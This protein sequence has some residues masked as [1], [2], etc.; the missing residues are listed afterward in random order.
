MNITETPAW[1]AL[2]EH[3]G[4]MK[5]RHLRELFASDPGRFSRFSLDVEG[6]LFDYSKQRIAPKTLDLLVALADAARLGTQIDALFSGAPVNRSEHRAALHM[7]LRHLDDS[8]FPSS[9][10]GFED[11][12]PQVRA[13]RERMG[14]LVRAIRDGAL[15]GASGEPIRAVVNLGVGGSGLG[16]KMATQALEHLAHPGLRVF[17]VSNFDD[18][19]LWPVLDKL[20]PRSTLF[21]VTSKTFTT[22]ETLTNA[23]SARDWLLSALGAEAAMEQFVAVTG[24]AEAAQAFGIR[25]DRV[26][27]FW[28]WVGG[29]FSLWSAVGLPIA[30][31]IGMEH[32][33]NFLAGGAA[34]DRHFRAAPFS[35]N[36]PVLMALIGIWNTNFLGAS[37][38]LLNPYCQ[39]L[40]WL[41]GY[42]QQLEMESNGKTLGDDAD[43]VGADTAPV[44]WGGIG[45]DTQH[46]Y[47]QLLH[48][49]GRLIPCD[50]IACAE[51]EAALPGHHEQLLANCLAQAEALAFGS[52][53]LGEEEDPRKRCP[54]NQPSSVF[55]LPRLGPFQLGLLIA[56]YEHK[57]FTQGAIWG[58]N[59]F[60]Q[61]GVE[62]GKKLARRLLPAIAGTEMPTG[63]D[64]STAG[65]IAWLRARIHER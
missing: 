33:E 12:M 63:S 65:L 14:E 48:Q 30:I 52:A 55:L 25:P 59:P 40:C 42:L 57:V 5:P 7:A 10:S 19:D 60:D 15:R 4:E 1:K 8:P 29:R 20:D 11:V 27:P 17:H 28:E 46:A 56:A 49:G 23:R 44:L 61:W 64:T 35:A 26:Y 58:I 43:P 41:P 18:A 34:M 31:S 62:L 21:I 9:D 36:L 6:M 50:F 54:G 32:F 45:S 38:H 13:L 47:F 53:V 24:N 22:Q 51:S 37:T 39:P 16:P 3:A 2:A